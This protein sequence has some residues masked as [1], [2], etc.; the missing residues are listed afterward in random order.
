VQNF[1]QTIFLQK[2]SQVSYY[3]KLYANINSLKIS[4]CFAI[5][6][7]ALI[8]SKALVIISLNTQKIPFN[9]EVF[10]NLS[11]I[12]SSLLNLHFS[13]NL[14]ASNALFFGLTGETFPGCQVDGL[15]VKPKR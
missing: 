2:S 7:Q 6:L 8:E 15:S 3:F 14:V 10:K 13:C 11:F 4:Q 12:P 9:L 5:L 1:I